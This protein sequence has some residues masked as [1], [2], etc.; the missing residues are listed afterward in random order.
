MQRISKKFKSHRP[1][2]P[3]NIFLSLCLILSLFLTSP[4]LWPAC[5]AFYFSNF[6]PLHFFSSSLPQLKRIFSSSRFW[7]ACSPPNNACHLSFPISTLFF[8]LTHPPVPGQLS[9][10]R[11]GQGSEAGNLTMAELWQVNSTPA[12]KLTSV[13]AEL[14]RHPVSKG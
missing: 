6:L 3:H 8:T 10:A 9:S 1:L 13:P 7:S 2:P 12:V 14:T 4:S 5:F 11:L